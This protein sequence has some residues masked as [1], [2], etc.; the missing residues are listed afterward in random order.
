MSTTPNNQPNLNDE[1]LANKKR[2]EFI[3]IAILLQLNKAKETMLDMRRMINNLN[4]NPST[5]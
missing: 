1:I 5:K 4:I 3:Q 2:D